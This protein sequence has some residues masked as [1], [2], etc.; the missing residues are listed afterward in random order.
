MSLGW[1][2][3]LF[4]FG[5]IIVIYLIGR[6]IDAAGERYDLIRDSKKD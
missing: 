2:V 5:I 3:V 1:S 6:L 4:N